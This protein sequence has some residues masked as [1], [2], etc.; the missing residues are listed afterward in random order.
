M[1]LGQPIYRDSVINGKFLAG[2]AALV[3][4]AL[5]TVAVM[6]GITIPMLGFA[7]TLE[8][9]L[10]VVAMTLLTAVYLILWLSIGVL[11]SV[12]FKRTST[13][14]LAS[15]ATWMTFSVVISILASAL[16]GAL[17]PLPGGDIMFT[18]GGQGGQG[19]Q[20]GPESF[21]VSEEFMQ[22]MQERM[23]LQSAI[24]NLSPTQLYQVTAS[25]LL[26]TSGFGGGFR[27]FARTLTLGE[28]LA[29][30]W[31]SIAALIVGT[32]V[33]FAASYMMFLRTE[34]RPGE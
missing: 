29:N 8:E 33:A 10:K 32:V 16:A 9:A 22:A 6:C 18:P 1:V 12:V 20:G 14:I 15:I 24:N 5:T 4:V 2:A 34:I 13:S 17:V 28:A 3:T 7:P 27:E 23:A 19:G 31:A 25:A 26:G 11:Y 21:R 30:N